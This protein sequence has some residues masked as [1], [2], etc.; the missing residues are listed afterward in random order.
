MTPAPSSSDD[1]AVSIA[2]AVR[3]DGIEFGTFISCTGLGVQIETEKRVEGGVNTFVHVLPTNASFSNITLTRPVTEATADVAAWVS[4]FA[5][6]ARPTTGSIQAMK[7]DGTV[8]VEFSL[9]GVIPVKWTGPAFSVETPKV[10][11]ETLELAH[12]GFR[13]SKG[14]S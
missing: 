14:R 1:P 9:E 10:A 7:A 5:D 8:L 11:T 13:P 6:S 3:I 4:E 12:H 2:F